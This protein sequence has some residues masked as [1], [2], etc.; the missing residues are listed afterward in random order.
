ML[1]MNPTFAFRFILRLPKFFRTRKQFKKMSEA[2]ADYGKFPLLTSYPMLFEADAEGGTARGAYFWQDLLVAQ[3]I[4]R[5]NPGRHLD[6]GSRIDGFV[7][8]V[9]S[10]REIE[11]MD[12]R[13][14]KNDLPNIIFRQCDLMSDVPDELVGVADSLSCLH[15]LEHFG[16]GRYGDPLDPDGHRKG[17]AN[18][19]RILKPGGLLYLS[20][21]FGTQGIHFNAHRIF[22]LEYLLD[23]FK[24]HRFSVEQ[25]SFVGDGGNI[26]FN[27]E[28]TPESVKTNCNQAG[29]RNATAIFEL[30][31]ISV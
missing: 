28:L 20:V 9:A 7:A 12:I 8:H 14:L 4:A 29:N 17:F 10:F 22:S 11:V 31:K 6:V 18:L 3:R 23:M 1:Q 15:A 5:A 24:T 2:S 27:I 25:F 21:P 26:R 30:K 13:P 16:L 19:A